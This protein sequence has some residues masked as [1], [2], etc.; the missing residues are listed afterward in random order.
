M[1]LWR[2]DRERYKKMYFDNRDELRHDNMGMTYGKVVA[3]AL[4][5]SRE[6]GDLLT[7]AAMLMLP[8]YDVADQEIRAQLKTT[9][10]WL[11]LLGKPDSMDSDSKS[12][13][14]YKTGKTAWTQKKADE[15]LQMYFYAAVIYTKYKILP[16]SAQLVW[17]ETEWVDDEVKPTGRVETFHV[18]MR[19]DRVLATLGEMIDTAYE[20]E[21]AFAAHV[22]DERILTF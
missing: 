15:H 8:K 19:L 16:P 12:F 18:P 4:E 20:I 9:R 5:A 13:L 3:D 7:D 2:N 14:E 11:E 21:I 17:I 6:T 10:G 22:P 1:Q